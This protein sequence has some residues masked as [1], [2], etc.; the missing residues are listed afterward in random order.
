MINVL[1]CCSN[2]ETSI[3]N[4]L[5]SWKPLAKSYHVLVNNTT[6]N[7]V[8][9][10]IRTGL[11]VSIYYDEF[12]DFSQIRNSLLTQSGLNNSDG[13]VLMIDDSYELKTH[14]GFELTTPRTAY[15]VTVHK[16][17]IEFKRNILF[18][19]DCTYTGHV[20][21]CV[22]FDNL[23]SN[24]LIINDVFYPPHEKRTND[25][26][27]S[28]LLALS[29]TNTDRSQ[30]YRIINSGD[31]E[32]M[33]GYRSETPE[34]MYMMLMRLGHLIKS[35]HSV[36]YFI[37]ASEYIPDLAPECYFKAWLFSGRKNHILIKTAAYKIVSLNTGYPTTSIP[38]E[39]RLF[40]Y[41]GVIM[42]CYKTGLK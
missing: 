22:Q 21:E 9:E 39:L 42:N 23:M 31:I 35:E 25:R 12:R 20:H 38:Y 19:P 11:P 7:T 3:Y 27:H 24:G 29:K 33:S 17:N 10:I 13:L 4:T 28:D 32:L 15:S 1:C 36:K 6:D 41:D 18:T 16:Q 26:L 2:S 40:G 30:F 37:L 5:M 34:Y 14:Q 8:S